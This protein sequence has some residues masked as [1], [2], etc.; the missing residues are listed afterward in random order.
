VGREALL[1]LQAVESEEEEAEG[2]T[3]TIVITNGPTWSLSTARIAAT[4]TS[5]I[6]GVATAQRCQ[7]RR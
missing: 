1:A 2:T 6:A 4:A 7:A 3:A 5:T